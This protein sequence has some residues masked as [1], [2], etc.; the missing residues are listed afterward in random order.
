MLELTLTQAP[1]TFYSRG[2]PR[3]V[4]VDHGEFNCASALATVYKR[5]RSTPARQPGSLQLCEL[6]T[7]PKGCELRLPAFAGVPASSAVLQAMDGSTGKDLAKAKFRS[8]CRPQRGR[9][10]QPRDQAQAP[11]AA[12]ERCALA[13]PLSVSACQPTGTF[14]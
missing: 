7:S 10:V 11:V 4:L 6:T 8:H 9:K 2:K 1:F 12:Q 3:V 14:L 13:P 5:S